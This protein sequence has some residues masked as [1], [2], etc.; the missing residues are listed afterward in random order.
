MTNATKAKQNARIR[1]LVPTEIAQRLETEAEFMGVGE[2]CFRVGDNASIKSKA[3]IVR[4]AVNLYVLAMEREEPDVE[5]D[6]YA[7]TVGVAFYMGTK[8]RGFWEYAIKQ[9]MAESIHD[10]ASRALT[11][12]FQ[13]A[14]QLLEK[15]TEVYLMLSKFSTPDLQA[16]LKERV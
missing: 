13:Q 12:Y 15:D 7:G 3:D 8:D 16:W 14:D 4:W 5:V 11:R 1:L 9:H 2:H 10:L 6:L